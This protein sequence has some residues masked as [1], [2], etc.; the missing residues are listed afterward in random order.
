[1]ALCKAARD[2]DRG[3]VDA[4]LG[5]GVIKLRVARRGKGKSGGYRTMVLYKARTRAFFVYGFAKSDQDNIRDDELVALK[6]LA[7]ELLTYPD[8]TL[9]IAIASGTLIEVMCE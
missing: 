6:A 7:S 5:G 9:A 4:D 3:I 8:E 2:A 1:M